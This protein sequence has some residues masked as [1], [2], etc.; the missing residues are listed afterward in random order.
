MPDPYI[1]VSGFAQLHPRAQAWFHQLWWDT[2]I[3][4][5]KQKPERTF[6]VSTRNTRL[7]EGRGEWIVLPGDL[8]T[9]HQALHE[10]GDFFMPGC[11]AMWMVGAWLAYSNCTDF[12]YVEQDTLAF[13]P[14]LERLDT[15]L[16]DKNAIFGAGK[17]HGGSSTS[18][19]RI[20]HRYIPQW[21][22][23]YIDQGPEDHPNRLPEQKWK[24]MAQRWPEDYVQ[25]TFGYDADRPFNPGD[26]VWYGQQFTPEELLFIEARGLISCAGMPTKDIT[27]FSNH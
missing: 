3:S 26:E 27:V 20:R 10:G 2:N 19:F 17:M 18:L 9:C 16:G 24:R 12:V 1:I 22:H 13:G 5:L 7:P 14:W 6:I 4:K 23:D 8:G 15:E 11:P 21:V 25:F